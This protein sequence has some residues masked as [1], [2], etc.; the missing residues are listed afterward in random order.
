MS[1]I[2]QLNEKLKDNKVS[3]YLGFEV[4]I[5]S[6]NRLGVHPYGLRSKHGGIYYT[7][8]YSKIIKEANRILE[9]SENY[10]QKL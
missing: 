9:E 6:A 3:N 4:E 7:G 10:C 8:S 2:K 5:T 1:R